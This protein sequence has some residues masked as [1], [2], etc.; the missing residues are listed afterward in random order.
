MKKAKRSKKYFGNILAHPGSIFFFFFLSK[1]S[2]SQ[3]DY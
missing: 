2:A 1:V 3:A